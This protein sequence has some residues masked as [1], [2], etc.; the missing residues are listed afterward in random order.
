[1]SQENVEIVRNTVAACLERRP[2]DQPRSAGRK[3]KCTRRP[4]REGRA[5]E[6]QRMRRPLN[7]PVRR[8]LAPDM[9]A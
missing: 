1:M 4:D 6:S 9:Q 3:T 2:R 7:K 8:D 5:A